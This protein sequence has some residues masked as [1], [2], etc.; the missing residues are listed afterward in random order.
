MAEQERGVAYLNGFGT[1]A[2]AGALPEDGMTW[3]K[4]QYTAVDE[5][6]DIDGDV[7]SKLY[8]NPRDELTMTILV[9]STGALTI[10]PPDR[11][12]QLTVTDPGG[13]STGYGVD[14]ATM[15]LSRTRAKL[16]LT[17]IKEVG[18]S[19]T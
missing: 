16:S 13:S 19:Y 17:L 7:V 15:T 9:E 6:T 12:S 18:M 8:Q 1:F 14:D 4:N 10:T 5:V 2:F 3:K 11:G